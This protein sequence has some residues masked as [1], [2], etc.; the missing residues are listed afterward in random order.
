M[1][2]AAI[3]IAPASETPLLGRFTPLERPVKHTISN[4]PTA[5]KFHA[6]YEQAILFFLAG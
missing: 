2:P 5:A 6:C 1:H 4:P 3:F